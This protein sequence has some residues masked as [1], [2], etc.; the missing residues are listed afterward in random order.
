[1]EL[2]ASPAAARTAAAIDDVE[3]AEQLVADLSALIDA[4]LVAPV[5][6]PIA[7]ARYEI[8]EDGLHA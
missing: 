6:D 2:F 4:G 3:Q 5:S 8:T 1:L 7:T